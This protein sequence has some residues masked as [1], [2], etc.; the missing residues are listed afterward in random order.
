M[1]VDPMPVT[2][3]QDSGEQGGGLL[4][5]SNIRGEENIGG[6]RCEAKESKRTT[7]QEGEARCSPLFVSHSLWSQTLAT[8]SHRLNYSQTWEPHLIAVSERCE[9]TVEQ[10]GAETRKK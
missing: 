5:A 3:T 9:R 6:Y 2:S 10:L 7:S 8:P 4:D 1:R